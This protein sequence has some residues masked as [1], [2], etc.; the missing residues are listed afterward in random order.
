MQLVGGWA[1]GGQ[2]TG[3]SL[4]EPTH[5]ETHTLCNPLHMPIALQENRDDDEVHGIQEFIVGGAGKG[6][7]HI[8]DINQFRVTKDA[9]H[10][11]LHPQ[12]I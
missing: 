7:V 6:A 4:T 11:V 1:S 10:Y 8:S 2:G 3:S 9:L 12:G 5:F